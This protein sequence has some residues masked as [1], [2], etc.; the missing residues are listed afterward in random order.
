[1]VPTFLQ[2]APAFTAAKLNCGVSN[3]PKITIVSRHRSGFRIDVS[4][5]QETFE[6]LFLPRLE[7]LLSR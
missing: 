5:A 7:M 3:E 4:N 6:R 1:V 2:E